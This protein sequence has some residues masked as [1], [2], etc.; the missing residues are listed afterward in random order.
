M[1][2]TQSLEEPERKHTFS[3]EHWNSA[4][5]QFQAATI[6]IQCPKS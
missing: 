6:F 5:S 2:K 4:R 3:P 1:T